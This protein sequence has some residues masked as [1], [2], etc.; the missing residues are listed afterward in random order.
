VSDY[1]FA[2]LWIYL[3]EIINNK[4]RFLEDN[5]FKNITGLKELILSYNEMTKINIGYLSDLEILDFASNK[6]TRIDQELE[7]AGAQ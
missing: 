7:K 5:A 6:L 4:I 1:S 2:N 3:I